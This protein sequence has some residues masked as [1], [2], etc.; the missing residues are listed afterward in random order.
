MSQYSHINEDIATF[1]QI[2]TIS[3]VEP[4]STSETTFVNQAKKKVKTLV[5]TLSVQGE[6]RISEAGGGGGG[7]TVNY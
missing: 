7:V 6:Y 3:S 1:N 2:E 5:I 4:F